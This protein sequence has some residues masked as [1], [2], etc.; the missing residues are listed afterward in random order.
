MTDETPTITAPP[1]PVK[2]KPLSRPVKILFALFG[3]L[4]LFGLALNFVGSS[5][6]ASAPSSSA[7]AT[8]SAPST[9]AAMPASSTTATVPVDYSAAIIGSWT[10]TGND[11]S[12]AV[13][14]Y[15]NTGEGIFPT[16][17]GQNSA[18]YTLAGNTLT[19]ASPTGAQIISSV[20]I[21]GNQMRVKSFTVVG[22]DGAQ[23][24]HTDDIHKVC[25]RQ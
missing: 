19:V 2:R 13:E 22:A 12:Q 4:G 8:T 7:S 10:C 25:T 15:T 23:Q 17:S 3:C 14:I 16:S 5:G 18:P 11:G 6:G 1:V 20:T 9:S 21:D 24:Y